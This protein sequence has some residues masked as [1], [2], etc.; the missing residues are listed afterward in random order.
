[1]KRLTFMTLLALAVTLVCSY[2]ANA[3]TVSEND[4]AVII[5]TAMYEV[6]W[7]KGAQMGYT[8][9]MVNGNAVIEGDA[10]GRRMYHSANYNSWRDWGALSDWELVDNSPGMAVV[11]YESNDGDRKLYAVMATYYDAVE[12]IRHDVTVEN[13]SGQTV[14]SFSDGHEPMFEV[15]GPVAGM[16][17]SADPIPHVAFW[18]AAGYGAL[19]TE[20]GTQEPFPDWANALGNGRMHLVHNALGV[21]LNPGQTS[22]PIVYYVAFGRG[23]EAEANA[24][25]SRV[26]EPVDVGTAVEPHN[27][28]TTTWG[29]L[30]R[31]E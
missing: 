18:N 30:K 9:A 17:D 7:K 21:E 31:S 13:I 28:L 4:Q 25:A 24:L 23:G 2:V 3:V 14:M 29:A 8:T 19:Y 26:T 16:S 20:M 5:E 15:R 10:E 12:F 27:K 11:R 6:H 22:D 1:M